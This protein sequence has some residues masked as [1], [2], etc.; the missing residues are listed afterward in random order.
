MGEHGAV[1]I[2]PAGVYYKNAPEVSVK[3]TVGA[4]DAMLAGFIAGMIRSEDDKK[5]LDIALETATAS[6]TGNI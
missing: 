3:S 5:L 6:V 1:L 2:S 4:G